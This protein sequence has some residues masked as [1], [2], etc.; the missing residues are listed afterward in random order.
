ML[1]LNDLINDGKITLEKISDERGTY[2]YS[3]CNNGIKY[4]ME[5]N[6]SSE[7]SFLIKKAAEYCSYYA[8]DLIIS[9][10][11]ME[12]KMGKIKEYEEG[13]GQLVEWFGFR[14]MGV[15]HDD[16]I[17]SRGIDRDEYKAIYIIVFELED[18]LTGYA[19]TIYYYNAT[20]YKV[21]V[22]H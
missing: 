10:N 1:N 7:Y 15:D 2:W 20:L 8:S 22:N 14:D 17:E 12:K 21:N 13:K 16:F 6:L 3:L 4:H 19:D 11:S 9:I 5:I 18:T